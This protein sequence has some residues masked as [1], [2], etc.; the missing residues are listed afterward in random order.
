MGVH[1]WEGEREREKERWSDRN[2]GYTCISMH[3]DRGRRRVCAFVRP[4]VFVC[5]HAYTCAYMHT[6]VRA[7]AEDGVVE[8]VAMIPQELA[9]NPMLSDVLLLAQVCK[10]Q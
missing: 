8:F 5:I 1:V 6:Q 9:V 4:C 7:V 2:N 3:R 10:S